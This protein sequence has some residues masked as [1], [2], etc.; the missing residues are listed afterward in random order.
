MSNDAPRRRTFNH[1]V[2]TVAAGTAIQQ[3]IGPAVP[4]AGPSQPQAAAVPGSEL[5]AM[6][7]VELTERLRKKQV[8]ARHVMTAHLGQIER[9]NPR[10]NAIVTLVADRAM[11]DAAKA[12]DA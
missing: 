1:A 9:V 3:R 10:V 5:C 2:G 6:S 7:A 8:S 12:D 4:G 11:A